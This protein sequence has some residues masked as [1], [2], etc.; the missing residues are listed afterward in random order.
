MP[1]F[2]LSPIQ[3]ERAIAFLLYSADPAIALP[4]YRV[5]FIRAQSG[6]EIFFDQQCGGCHR[7]LL[8]TGPAGRAAVGPNLTGLFTP[9][10]PPTAPGNRPWTPDALRKWLRNP[11]AIRASTTMPP[12]PVDEH[13]WPKL[14]AELTGSAVSR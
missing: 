5:H 4:T 10:Y 8:A 2:A 13:R 14:V 1:R 12:I 6:S 7:A 11:R 9:F 3:I